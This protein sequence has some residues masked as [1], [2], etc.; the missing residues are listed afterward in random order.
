MIRLFWDAAVAV[1]PAAAALDQGGQASITDAGLEAAFREAGF[2]A[3]EAGSITIPMVFADFDDLWLPF[4]GGTGGAPG[5]LATLDDV[6]RD[7]IREQLRRSITAEPDGSIHLEARAWTVRARQPAERRAIADP[8]AGDRGWVVATEQDPEVRLPRADGCVMRGGHPREDLRDV[9][10][11]VDR[12]CGEQLAERDL[13]EGG[14]EASSVEIRLVGDQL[15]Q[16]CQ[17]LRPQVSETLDE[18]IQRL[19]NVPVDMGEAIER[20]ERLRGPVLEDPLCTRDPVVDLAR[21]QVADDIA[22]PP[23]STTSGVPVQASGTPARSA[24]TTAGVR[25]RRSTLSARDVDTEAPI[26]VDGQAEALLDACFWIAAIS[27]WACWWSF[28]FGCW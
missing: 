16:A 26:A 9:I 14:M 15:V 6:H 4:L 28:S 27:I 23:A 13:A 2:V 1:D 21:D 20:V 12:P 5:Y 11:V 3:V 25:R 8:S 18:S 24:D 22:R 10:Q 17:A 7:A 19:V